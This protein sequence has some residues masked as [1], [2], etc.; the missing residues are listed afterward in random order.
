MC[1][2]AC[3]L[4]VGIGNALLLVQLT[5][6]L[7]GRP[8]AE[9]RTRAGRLL[10]L[11]LSLNTLMLVPVLLPMLLAGMAGQRM[12]GL[13]SAWHTVRGALPA[14]AMA[15]AW[16]LCSE[17][18][19]L[20]AYLQ[21]RE[22]QALAQNCVTMLVLASALAGLHAAGAA[23][24]AAS[25]LAVYAAA[26]ALGCVQAYGAARPPLRHA[27]HLLREEWRSAWRHGRWALGGVGITWL[28]GQAYAYVLAALA[29][30]AGVGLANMA[31]IFISPFSFLLPA[32]NKIAMPRL[33]EL[34]ATDPARTRR[35]SRRLTAALTT[36]ALA[37]GIGLSVLF[38]PAQALL[39]GRAVPGIVP[40]VALWCTI[41]VF[42][43]LRSGGSV[44]LQIEQRFRA[45]TLLNLPS[46]AVALAATM[47]LAWL[48]GAPGALLGLLAGELVLT[49]LIWKE[50]RHV[51]LPSTAAHN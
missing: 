20:Y 15:A 7:P 50:I 11:V 47:P 37:Y 32:V 51:S 1:Y 17:F 29:G 28:Q 40:L 2:G 23:L 30:P 26:A 38:E 34:R 3:L 5:I 10:A 9:Q 13:P 43:V 12:D 22:R 35:L 25:V 48:Y 42:Q 6:G 33:A 46:A 45:L 39:L 21:R 41:L 49:Y 36:L 14:A 18:F 16:F 4:Y 19:I 31:R 24:T 8:A 44:L 27:A